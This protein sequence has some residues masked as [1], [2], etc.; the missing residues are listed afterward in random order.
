MAVTINASTTAGLVQ[1]ADTTGNLN[2]QSNGTTI[3]AL[4][5]AGLAVTGAGTFSTTLGVTGTSTLATVNA[6]GS[7]LASNGGNYLFT[8]AA[9][10]YIG[11]R[12]TTGDGY[13]GVNMK[14]GV[15]NYV[16]NGFAGQ[17][18]FGTTGA[19]D[20]NTA[21]SGTAG[22][23]VSDTSKMTISNA[24]A[25]TIPGTLAVTGAAT[26]SSTLAVGAVT[27]TSA[28][29]HTFNSSV[30]SFAMNL[31][32][33][34]GGSPNGLSVYYS[35]GVNGTG[36]PFLFCSDGA[37]VERATIRSNGGLANFSA[38]NVNLSDAT[39]KSRIEPMGTQWDAWKKIEWM[40]FKYDDQTH[41]DW[42]Y[43]YTAQNI[44]SI[45]PELVDA[46]QPNDE[47]STLKAVYS[48]D[49]KNITGSVLQEA[50]L[51]IEQLE[52]RLAALEAK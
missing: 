25:V 5:S 11:G 12:S 28:A 8:G 1:T 23:A 20:F 35:S 38:N 45:Y 16:V 2:L 40:K 31:N 24:G 41:D 43:G 39:V 13:I 51:R 18:I 22:N 47:N 33:T 17:I 36:N 50:Q 37:S 49:L 52:A 9:P 29:T 32:N 10:V 21:A 15:G 7:I 48:E 14:I 30:A 34:S 6:S 19:W 26:L 42:N 3:A 46:W 4:T 27:A 44:E